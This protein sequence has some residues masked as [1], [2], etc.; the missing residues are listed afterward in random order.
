MINPQTL[1][2]ILGYAL[3]TFSYKIGLQVCSTSG[4]SARQTKVVAT[5]EEIMVETT[6]KSKSPMYKEAIQK[7][8]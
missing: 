8:T 6:E 3:W 7:T 1:L 4:S 5:P 2:K